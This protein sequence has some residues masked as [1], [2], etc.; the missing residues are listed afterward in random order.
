MFDIS[1]RWQ[2][3]AI[4][5]VIYSAVIVAI[6]WIMSKIELDNGGEAPINKEKG[7]E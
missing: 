7:K 6:L 5:I 1:L 2:D 4:Q 3:G